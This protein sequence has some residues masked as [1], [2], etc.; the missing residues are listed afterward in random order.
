M[1]VVTQ[2]PISS[3]IA[4]PVVVAQAPTLAS[5]RSAQRQHAAVGVERQ[6]GV[7]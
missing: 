3:W 7:G 4:A 2:G 1:L 5:E 6:L